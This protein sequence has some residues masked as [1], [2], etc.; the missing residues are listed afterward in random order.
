[1][2]VSKYVMY[3]GLKIVVFKPLPVVSYFEFEAHVYNRGIIALHVL[4]CPFL[5][6]KC[7]YFPIPRH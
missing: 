2:C 7:V 5:A 1:M 3:F 4:F 6:D